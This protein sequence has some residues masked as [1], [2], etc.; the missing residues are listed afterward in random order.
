MFKFKARKKTGHAKEDGEKDLM[1]EEITLSEKENPKSDWLVFFRGLSWTLSN[2]YVGTFCE[3]SQR[4]KVV[5]YF[6]RKLHHRCLM[7]S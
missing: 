4:L 3:N 6:P 5:S 1:M 7:G 2:I